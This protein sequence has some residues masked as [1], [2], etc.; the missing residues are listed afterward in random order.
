MHRLQIPPT[1]H[2]PR[3]LEGAALATDNERAPLRQKCASNRLEKDSFGRTPEELTKDES[4]T[5]EDPDVC[6]WFRAGVGTVPLRAAPSR[7]G[8]TRGF[9]CRRGPDPR[10][11]RERAYLR[12]GGKVRISREDR[13]DYREGQI[14]RPQ[15]L[16]AGT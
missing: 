12:A 2:V 6:Y 15:Y 7:S 13:R 8:A 5:D 14:L 11:Q 16:F 4:A 9:S 3:F 1:G 10:D